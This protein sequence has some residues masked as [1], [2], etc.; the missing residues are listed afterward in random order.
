M[1]KNILFDLD[2]TLLPM[3]QDK[4]LK[5]YMI[6][7]YEC[8]P[9]EYSNIEEMINI[10]AKG[11]GLMVNNDGKISNEKVF[12]NYFKSVKNERTDMLLEKYM[13][14]YRTNFIKILTIKKLFRIHTKQLFLFCIFKIAPRWVKKNTH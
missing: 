5:L 7:L 8:F 10:I 4:F 12:Y 14:Y 3:D 9:N 13:E 6:S 11:I 2:G 1:I